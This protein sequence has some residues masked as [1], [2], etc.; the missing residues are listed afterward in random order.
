MRSRATG[1]LRRLAKCVCVRIPVNSQRLPW[2]QQGSKGQRKHAKSGQA[3]RKEAYAE[4]LALGKSPVRSVSHG[5]EA[6]LARA[7][8]LAAE[9]GEW[10][11]VSDLSRQLE[12]LRRAHEG[13][14]LRVVKGSGQQR[15]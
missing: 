9:A 8:K 14:R 11:V 2:A 5:P 3:P 12:A 7:L 6:D 15:R 4:D 1:V 10:A 13:A